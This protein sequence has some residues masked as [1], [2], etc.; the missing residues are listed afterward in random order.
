MNKKAQLFAE[1]VQSLKEDAKNDAGGDAAEE[2]FH[3]E[4]VDDDFHTVLFRSQ[5]E[6]KDSLLLPMVLII[7]DSLYAV[8]RV[9]AAAGARTAANQEALAAYMDIM[10]R[11]YKVF[12]YYG[13]EEGDII[14]DV[15][16]MADAEHF[17]PVMA[18]TAI[19]LVL[20]HL[21]ETRDDLEA[22][23]Q[24]RLPQGE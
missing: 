8:L 3:V 5:L 12:K 9:W 24:G 16:L 13:N 14:L 23:I 11:R 21:Q 1:L 19:D 20:Q 10:N 6:I 7:D 22:A 2:M 15:C 18:T 17:D 4:E